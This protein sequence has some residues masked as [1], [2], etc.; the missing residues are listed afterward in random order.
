MNPK[1]ARK[2]SLN[3]FILKKAKKDAMV[4]VFEKQIYYIGTYPSPALIRHERKHLEQ[5]ERYGK[6]GYLLMW[7][8]YNLK[9]GY[10]NNPLEIEAREAE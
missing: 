2:Y 6:V 10:A 5:I 4:D 7:N 8:F 1:K 9:Y 3:W